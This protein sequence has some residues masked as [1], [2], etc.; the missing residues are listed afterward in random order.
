[1]FLKLWHLGPHRLGQRHPQ[2]HHRA[3]GFLKIPT[4]SRGTPS[5]CKPVPSP[6][7]QTSSSTSHAHR[8]SCWTTRDSAWDGPNATR[9][10]QTS[11][12]STV[13]T[14]CAALP[15]HRN[16]SNSPGPHLPSLLL[17][18]PDGSAEA[19]VL[20]HGVPNP[21]GKWGPALHA[22]S[23]SHLCQVNHKG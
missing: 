4:T 7:P 18:P 14:A 16:P 22:V 10:I 11:Q 3:S 9:T 17:L 2:P 20:W 23:W 6:L 5:M 12:S 19:H 8:A 13:G 15:A 1:M 21:P